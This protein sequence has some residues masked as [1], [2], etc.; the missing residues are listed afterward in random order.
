M[1]GINIICAPI[2]RQNCLILFAS[3]NICRTSDDG[4]SGHDEILIKKTFQTSWL[5]GWFNFKNKVTLYYHARV[6]VINPRLNNILVKLFIFKYRAPCTVTRIRASVRSNYINFKEG[7]GL[8]CETLFFL[9]YIRDVKNVSKVWL[10]WD[11]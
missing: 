10:M 3:I 11:G 9:L 2:F 7:T 4:I 5:V 6:K 1:S 8:F